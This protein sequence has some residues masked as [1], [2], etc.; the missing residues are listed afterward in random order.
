M[1]DY[2]SIYKSRFSDNN[3]IDPWTNSGTVQPTS[4]AAHF[5]LMCEDHI[6][7]PSDYM[8]GELHVE[9]VFME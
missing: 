6:L 7:I 1:C 5:P 3:P 8:L 9:F 4:V 2:G